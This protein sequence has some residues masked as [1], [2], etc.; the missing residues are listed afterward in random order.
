MNRKALFLLL[1]A[2]C[3]GALRADVIVSTSLSLTNLQITPGVGTLQL[4]LAPGVFGDV[5]DTLGDYNFAFDFS[6]DPAL[7]NASIPLAFINNS[8]SV[9]GGLGATASSGVSILGIDAEAGTDTGNNA[10]IT[11]TLNILDPGGASADPQSVDVLFTALLNASQ[12]LFTDPLGVSAFSEVTFA[13]NLPDLGDSGNNFLF[14]DN[15]E[16][17]GSDSSNSTSSTPTLSETAS[18]LTNTDY[19]FLLEAD[20]E[21]NG[22]NSTPEPASLILMAA[23]LAGLGARRLRRG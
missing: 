16:T 14:F 12:T 2:V 15:L 1:L 21:S 5:F 3:C 20:A 23:A 4:S 19:S 17:I 6:D 22:V 11:G 7:A 9:A 18:L 10:T 13:L 8:A